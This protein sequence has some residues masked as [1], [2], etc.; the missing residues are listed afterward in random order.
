MTAGN[1]P[2][3]GNE[4]PPTRNPVKLARRLASGGVALAKLEAERGRQEI[5][6]NLL[7][8]RTGVVLL[9]IAFGFVI[10]SVFVLMILVVLVI[11]ALTGLP[12]WVVALFMVLLLVAL[13][14]LFGWRGIIKIQA[15]TFTPEETIAA[16]KEDLEWA[17]RLLRR[18]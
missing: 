8:Y 3:A 1:D 15:S 4:P 14:A 12:G 6:E 18:G 11:S 9:A 5:T 7:Q 2:T 16:V 17:K 13:A 10:L